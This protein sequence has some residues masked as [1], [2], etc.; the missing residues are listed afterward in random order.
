MYALNPR[1][2]EAEAGNLCEFEASFVYIAS[3]GIARLHS[4]PVSQKKQ[5][6]KS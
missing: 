6:K 1:I 2:Q 4:E 5:K 3:F